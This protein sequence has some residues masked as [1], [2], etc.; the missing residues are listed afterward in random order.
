[1]SRKKQDVDAPMVFMNLDGSCFIAAPIQVILYLEDLPEIV[2]SAKPGNFKY[3]LTRLMNA[4]DRGDAIA[5]LHEL[6]SAL[7]PEFIFCN[8]GNVIRAFNHLADLLPA[9]HASLAM[10]DGKDE[11]RFTDFTGHVGINKGFDLEQ[12][13]A[14]NGRRSAVG[15][16]HPQLFVVGIPGDR[17]VEIKC[18]MTLKLRNDEGFVEDYELVAVIQ[19]RP[20][21]VWSRIKLKSVQWYNIDNASVERIKAEEVVNKQTRMLFYKLI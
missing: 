15:L 1:M 18:E 7:D 21:H 13:I 6:R 8:G 20:R 3:S 17:S 19:S 10:T 9:L 14:A 2:A 5:Y 12:L 16:K 4:K 11:F